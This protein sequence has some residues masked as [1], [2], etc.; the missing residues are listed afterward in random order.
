[1][2]QE[3]LFPWESQV[4]IEHPFAMPLF[5]GMISILLSILSWI[6]TSQIGKKK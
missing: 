4:M 6:R 5:M 2:L 3:W 1:M